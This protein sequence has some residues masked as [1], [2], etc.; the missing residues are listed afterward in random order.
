MS[1]LYTVMLGGKQIGTTAFEYADPSMGVVFGQINFEEDFYN[2][3]F[4]KDYCT[5]ETIPFF[6]DDD[7]LFISTYDLPNLQVNNSN[8]ISI[9]GLSNSIEGTDSEGFNVTITEID[10]VEY[11]VE[12][13]QHIQKYRESHK[14][15]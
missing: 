9:K 7:G 5:K 6:E 4:L 2:F 15:H 1:D 3:K 13:P 14:N 8:G 10:S 12:F 11:A